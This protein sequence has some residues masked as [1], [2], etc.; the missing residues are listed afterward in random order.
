MSKLLRANMARLW[1][2]RIFWLAFVFL[3]VWGT[4]Q[5]ILIRTDTGGPQCLDET[6]WII[7]LFIGVVLSVFISL[8][9]GVEFDDGTIK[10][11]IIMG[12][13]RS[14]IYFA[15][16]TVCIIAGWLMCL[17][18]LISSLLVGIPLLG[19]FRTELSAV[20]LQGICVFALIAAYAAIY[21]FVAMTTRSR[22]LTA[23]TCLLLAFLLLIAGVRIL[24]QLEQAEGYYIPNYELGEHEI[25]DEQN[26][27]W[28]PNSE[29]IRGTERRIYE[30]I[31]DILPGGQSIQ[32]SGV[33]D[34]SESYMVMLLASLGWV[35]ISSSCGV[36][37]FRK[38]DLK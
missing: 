18:Y 28:V 4:I 2:S 6:F 14:E 20:F 23:I 13:T 17:G 8:F 32:L 3:T 33:A 22:A 9:V 5:R 12:H 19:F 10:N 37:I 24:N 36:V 26:S 7:T 1:K 11:K 35:I 34:V 31:F 29:Y 25:A 27:E 30:T 38:R 15:N 16:V 21:C